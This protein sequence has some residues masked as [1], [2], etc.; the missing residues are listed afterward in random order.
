ME[1]QEPTSLTIKYK[2]YK[3]AINPNL[4]LKHSQKIP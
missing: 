2:F 3:S 1:P 4:P